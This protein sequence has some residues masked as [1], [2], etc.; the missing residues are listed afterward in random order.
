MAVSGKPRGQLLEPFDP[1]RTEGEL[2]ARLRERNGSRGA[3]AAGGACDDGGSALELRHAPEL[4]F[5]FGLRD[6]E[7]LDR[8]PRRATLGSAPKTPS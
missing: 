7:G 2:G 6:E 8:R 1:A 3:D 4:I 5:V